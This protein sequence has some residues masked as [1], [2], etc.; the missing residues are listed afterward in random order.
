MDRANLRLVDVTLVV[1]PM[2]GLLRE[3]GGML[4][5]VWAVG[6]ARDPEEPVTFTR[7][8]TRL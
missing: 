7:S 8:P 2:R 6:A 4:R 5:T 3:W 1:P